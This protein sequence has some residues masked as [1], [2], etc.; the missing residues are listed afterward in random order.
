MDSKNEEEEEESPHDWIFDLVL[1]FFRSP[2]WDE[3]V[4]GFVDMHCGIFLNDE[5]NKFEYTT[6]HEEFRDHVERIITSELTTVGITLELF[7]EACEA[8]RDSRAVN[9]EVIE[10]VLAM[11]DFL[12][13]KK[14]MVKR[15]VELEL[16]AIEELQSEAVP[17]M[18]PESAEEAEVQLQRAIKESEE[19]SE[20]SPEKA[21]RVIDA[22]EADAAGHGGGAR[23]GGGGLDGGG[24][25][26]GELVPDGTAGTELKIRQAMDSSLMEIERLHKAEEIEQLELEHALAESLALEH[27]RMLLARAA[28]MRAEHEAELAAEGGAKG[29]DGGGCM[30]GG[31][32]LTL[33]SSSSVRSLCLNQA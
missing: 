5:E 32:G 28:S 12:T 30:G 13:F 3:R 18:A 25:G 26:G 17:I 7:V 1:T 10:Q 33:G 11:D 31:G 8:A 20:M 22:A 6:L 23:A 21:S 2:E 29:D 27:E 15:N 4:M 16:E 19:M 14:L 9:K 24:L